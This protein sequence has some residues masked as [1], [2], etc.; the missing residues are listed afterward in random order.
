M[1]IKRLNILL[2]EDD[3]DDY[4]IIQNL[5]SHIRGLQCNIQW[6]SS[7][8][9]ALKCIDNLDQD[10]CLIDYRLG[11]GNGLDL[12]RKVRANGCIKPIIIL[13]GQ[14]DL[15]VD[16]EAME[17]GA[18]DYLVKGELNAQ[19]LE[20]SIR[21][22][23]KIAQ[24]IDTLR[25]A[26]DKLA[27]EVEERKKAEFELIKAK[28]AAEDASRIKSEFLSNVSHEI[29]TPMCTII[30]M[31]EL[32]SESALSQTQKT[33][34][35]TSMQAGN[36]LLRL[37]DEIIYISK[38]ESS[39]VEIEEV[40]FEFDDL[41]LK[42]ASLFESRAQEKGIQFT[43]HIASDVPVKL[44]GDP[45]HLEQ[46]LTHFISNAIKFTK[47]GEIVL[48]VLLADK[49]NEADKDASHKCTN[50]EMGDVKACYL[51][52]SVTDTG[53]GIPEQKLQSIFDSFY[54]ADSSNTRAYGGVGLGITISKKL[55]EMMGGEVW[56][57]SVEGKGSTFF[58]NV[59][60]WQQ[61]KN[62]KTALMNANLSGLKLLI[63]DDSLAYQSIIKDE[64]SQ[65]GATIVLA[66]NCAD[67]MQA[68]IKSEAAGLF[69]LVIVDCML[70]GMNNITFIE[71]IQSQYYRGNEIP[72]LLLGAYCKYCNVAQGG[73]LGVASCIKRPVRTAKL[74]AAIKQAVN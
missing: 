63:I 52:F 14:G 11:D 22:A 23:I 18:S 30:G 39:Q 61:I 20:R 28:K 26:H 47:Q 21:Y 48:N 6:V 38:I 19:V 41:P 72:V 3:K 58:F 37:I 50:K 9:E 13:T 27:L 33:Y 2:V 12:L 25:H 17:A 5:F 32:L 73:N 49:A 53:V 54:Q 40:S 1:V 68:L 8:S 31:S 44:I 60:L 35:K 4:L 36:D 7:Y 64:L 66:Q 70:P 57:E 29:R 51:Q 24:T 16:M 59:K 46:V 15:D 34:I 45:A 55:I 71:K 42:M 65:Q 67:G 56:V 74:V 43:C 62:N 69:D 10:V